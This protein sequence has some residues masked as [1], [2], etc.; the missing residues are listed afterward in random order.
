MNNPNF[1]TNPSN[2]MDVHVLN[3]LLFSNSFRDHT[4]WAWL[5][6]MLL[7]DNYEV[8]I[9]PYASNNVGGLACCLSG[10]SYG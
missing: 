5:F 6:Y 7:Y 4:K 10:E 2:V 1:F 3:T 9:P 8:S